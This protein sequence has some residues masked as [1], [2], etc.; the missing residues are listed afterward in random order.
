M[1]RKDIICGQER[2]QRYMVRLQEVQDKEK[3]PKLNKDA[4]KRFIRSALWE[5]A[6]KDAQNQSDDEGTLTFCT[7]S[8]AYLCNA[9][10]DKTSYR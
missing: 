4:S 2:V 9:V 1:K 6:H 3:A 5:Q 8:C 10:F 7:V